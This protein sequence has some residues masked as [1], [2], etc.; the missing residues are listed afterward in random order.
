MPELGIQQRCSMPKWRRRSQGR[1]LQVATTTKFACDVFPDEF[2]SG[3]QTQ[4]ISARRK[5]GQ[6]RS[7]RIS[8]KNGAMYNC[9]ENTMCYIGL[10]QRSGRGYAENSPSRRFLSRIDRSLRSSVRN[11]FNQG[12]R[13]N[14]TLCRVPIEGPGSSR[15]KAIH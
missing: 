2:T 6:L 15:P 13:I 10:V 3:G 1:R 14:E 7:S 8:S 4:G 12:Q 9:F 11:G 5:S